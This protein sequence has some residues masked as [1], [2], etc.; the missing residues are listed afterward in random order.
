[1]AIFIDGYRLR[2]SA[3]HG[4]SGGRKRAS[5]PCLRDIRKSSNSLCFSVFRVQGIVARPFTS[6]LIKWGFS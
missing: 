5:I 6:H 3:R 4:F 2:P 1:V